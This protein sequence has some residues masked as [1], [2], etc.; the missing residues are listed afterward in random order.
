MNRILFSACPVK[1]C[2]TVPSD[3]FFYRK[4][5]TDPHGINCLQN[6]LIPATDIVFIRS[7]STYERPSLRCRLNVNRRRTSKEVL[8]HQRFGI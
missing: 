1:R 2:E 6:E 4:P 7:V 8:K 3:F 5:P